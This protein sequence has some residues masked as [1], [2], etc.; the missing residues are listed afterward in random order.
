VAI[1][2][3]EPG[4][5]APLKPY[6]PRLV[7]GWS[8]E[9]PPGPRARVVDGSLVSVDISGFTALAERLSVNGRAGAEELVERISSVFEELIAVAERHG[10]D[11]LKFRG[12]ALLLL[13]VGDRHPERA[14]GAASDMQWTIEEIGG[15]E[16]SVGPVELRMSAGVHSADCHFFLTEVPH[17]E[18]VVCGPAATRVFELEDLAEAGEIV[19]SAETAARVDPAWLRE[20]RAAARVMARL[21]P[22]ASVV[23][24]PPDVTGRDLDLYVPGSL[25]THLAVASGEAEHRRVT[26]AFVKLSGIHALLAEHGPDELLERIDSLAAAVAHASEAY[27][28]TWLESD[29]DVDAFKLYL[30]AGAPSSTG[31][32]AEGM[33]RG[34]RE[35]LAAD[36]G[37]PIRAGSNRGNVFTGDIGAP[38]RRTYAVMGDA[39]NLA[40]RLT[41]RAQPG[42]LLATADVLDRALTRYTT[43]REPLLVKGKERAVMAHHV[44][45]PA[46]R[47]ETAQV[48]LIPVFG[49]ETELAALREAIDAARMRTFQVIELVAEP[50]MGKSRLVRE[51]PTLALGFQHLSASTDPYATSVAYS[52]WP[53]LLRPLVGITPDRTR[54]EAGVQLAA[55]VQS[56]TPDL[57]PWLPL[58]AIPFGASVPSTPEVDAL[59]A[60]RSHSLLHETVEKFLERVLLMPTLIVVEDT[61]WLDDGSRFLLRHLSAGQAPR[62]WLIVATTRPSGESILTAGGPGRRIE[63][64]PLAEDDAESFALAVAQ[65]HALSTDTVAT[66]AARAGGNPL[67]LRELVFAARHG[68]PDDLPESVETLLTTRIDTLEPAHRIMLRYASVVGPT[69]GLDILEAIAGGEIAGSS[70]PARWEQLGE[71]VVPFGDRLLAFRHDLVRATAYAG[72]SFRRR[73][74]IHL[75]VGLALEERGA[76]DGEVDAALLSLHFAEAGEHARAWRYASE[77]GR[78]AASSFANVVAAD[79]FERALAA[80]AELEDLSERDVGDVAEALG[81]VCERF[82]SYDRSADAY[83]RAL[84]V[85]HHD[86][87]AETRLAAKRGSLRERVG[88]YDEAMAIYEH[89]LGLLDSLPE[90][91]ELV[92]NR[93]AIEIGAAGVRYRQGRFEETIRWAELAA[94]RAEKIGDRARLA[95]SY[96]LI[97]GAYNELGRSEAIAYC[98]RAL[99]IFEEL[100]DYGGMGR[101]LNTLGIGF[102]YAGRWDESVAAYR[103]GGETLD[104]A[105]DVVGAATLANNEGEVLSDQGHLEEAEGPFQ[106]FSR[107]SRAAGYAVGEGASLNN[108]ARLDARAGRF[109]EAHALYAQAHEVFERIGSAAFRLEAIAR[110]AECYV[111]EGRYAEAIDL[112]AGEPTDDASSHTAILV[113][114]TLGYALHQARRPDEARPHLEESLRLARSA[115]S[116]YEEALS[117]RALSDTRAAGPDA[118]AQAEE[119]LGRLG[120]IRLP[121]VPLP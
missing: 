99:P 53:D 25:R 15:T 11:V 108:L 92:R 107:V 49:R 68:T 70:D 109:D 7:R 115:E 18:L 75:R 40:A 50:G 106:R 28:I 14:C 43:D 121:P 2:P 84:D 13:F 8:E 102:Y 35:I 6:L 112:L 33:L 17:R 52:I 47:R 82:G 73:R 64:Q 101:T 89:G 86:P 116:E 31:D 71:F 32:D 38:S 23:P 55:W 94:G 57:T 45:E 39:V 103:R 58:L 44:G 4:I 65:E 76:P 97:A 24:P 59:D 29:I 61:H 78:R 80:S 69:F 26:V 111:F 16:S 113:E 74:E 22:G 90:L 72:L 87:E 51:L 104:R 42:D 20:E 30:T 110:E 36:V 46:G 81:D 88:E 54:E 85:F 95:H 10:G 9:D 27:G 119:I 3:G 118:R 56:V 48:D 5:G 67:F 34:L 117:L 63:L 83:S 100:S 91:K 41:A 62:P 77:A 21:E 105:G 96:Y 19:V 93:T 37:L 66:L 12:D 114:R 1:A 60:A 79:L 98:E 120:V